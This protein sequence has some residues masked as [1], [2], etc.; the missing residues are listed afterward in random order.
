LLLL[1]LQEGRVLGI[2]W[3]A[4]ESDN[5]AYYSDATFDNKDPIGR[6]VLFRAG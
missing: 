1:W 6:S 5:Y 4:K 3:N 2:A